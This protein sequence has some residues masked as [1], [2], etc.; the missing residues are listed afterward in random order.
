MSIFSQSRHGLT[1]VATPQA[2]LDCSFAALLFLPSAF[3]GGGLAHLYVR[4][5][6]GNDE[7]GGH[8]WK[9]GTQA[10]RCPRFPPGLWAVTWEPRRYVLTQVSVKNRREPV[11]PGW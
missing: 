4:C 1:A 2:D 9:I 5:K 8:G 11:A 3:V 10:A 7:V 6:G